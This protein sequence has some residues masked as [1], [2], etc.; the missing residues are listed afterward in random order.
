MEHVWVSIYFI[1]EVDEFFKIDLVIGFDA[2]NFDH[3]VDFVVCYGLT[4]YFKYFFQVFRAYVPLSIWSIKWTGEENT[5]FWRSNIEN[6]S[7][8]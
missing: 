2:C 5:Y 1:E 7:I 3:G 8:K 4:K 6:A